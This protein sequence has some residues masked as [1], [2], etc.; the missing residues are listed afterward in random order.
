MKTQELNTEKVRISLPGRKDDRF[1][2]WRKILTG[3]DK[4][5][6]NG[7]VFRGDFIST[8]VKIFLQLLNLSSFLPGRLILTF[9]VFNSC[10]FIIP[11]FLF[12]FILKQMDLHQGLYRF[13]LTYI[14]Y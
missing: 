6:D 10:V 8:P 9:S 11:P 14:N 13:S 12:Y 3:I 7:Y 1:K 5:K 4:N 2:S